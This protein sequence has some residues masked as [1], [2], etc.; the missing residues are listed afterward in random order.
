LRSREEL[1]GWDE[2]DVFQGGLLDQTV[3]EPASEDDQPGVG[4]SATEVVAGSEEFAQ[5]AG[6]GCL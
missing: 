6:L 4:G 2:C 1:V 5:D 3:V